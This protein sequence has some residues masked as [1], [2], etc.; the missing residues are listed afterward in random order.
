MRL[1]ATTLFTALLLGAP[2]AGLASLVGTVGGGVALPTLEAGGAQEDGQTGYEVGLS[3]G[4]QLND[5]LRWDA[6]EFH[7]TGVD[8]DSAFGVFSTDS[9]AF[10]SG[11][12]VGLFQRDR[13][14]HPYVSAG[15]AGNRLS[16]EQGPTDSYRWGLEWSAGGGFEYQLDPFT[17]VGVRYR[18]RSTTVDGLPGISSG[19]V[20]LNMHTVNLEFVFGGE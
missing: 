1:L 8:H 3:L 12:R 19:D 15:V 11:L 20:R 18:Y 2:S 17:A 16:H 10:G 4:W 5:W 9:L 13:R 14:L 6:F 7:Y